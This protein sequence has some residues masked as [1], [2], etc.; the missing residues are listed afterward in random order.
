MKIWIYYKK[1]IVKIPVS[2]KKLH[3]GESGP[4]DEGW[5]GQWES[6]W[7]EGDKIYCII[8]TGK[9]IGRAHV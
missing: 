4:T 9:Q 5:S 6:Y 2:E 3:F 7:R 8:V 1:G